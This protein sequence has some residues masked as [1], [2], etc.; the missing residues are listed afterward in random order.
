MKAV[1]NNEEHAAAE[2]ISHWCWGG[3]YQGGIFLRFRD[4]DIK[5]R[6]SSRPNYN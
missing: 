4:K 5:L 6:A 1:A 2:Y 3:K